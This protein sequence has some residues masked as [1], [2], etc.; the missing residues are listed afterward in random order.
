M[1]ASQHAAEQIIKILEQ[2]EKGGQIIGAVC[3]TNNRKRVHRLWKRARLHVQ[4]P[5]RRR[6]RHERPLPLAA[7]P[8]HVWA[9]DFVEDQDVY[10]HVL[11][12]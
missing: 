4:R 7:Y 5:K 11:A 8:N 1:K 6:Q 3:R 9:Y 2:A 12:C 10:G